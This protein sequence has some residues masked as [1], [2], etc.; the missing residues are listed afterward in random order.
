MSEQVATKDRV[1]RW[2]VKTGDGVFHEVEAE[3]WEF[4]GN[5][6]VFKA[7]NRNIAWFLDVKWFREK[8]LE[9]ADQSPPRE[10]CALR[11]HVTVGF[12]TDV[13][14]EIQWAIGEIDRL[15]RESVRQQAENEQLR[16]LLQPAV[17]A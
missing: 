14:E 10:L 4:S 2:E 15:R 6:L 11:Q 16:K 17:A 13:R 8:E 9:R 3:S 1:S 5:G 7:K 12:T